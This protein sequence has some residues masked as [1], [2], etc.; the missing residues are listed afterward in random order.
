MAV[1]SYLWAVQTDDGREVC[2]ATADVAKVSEVKAR[3][4][5]GQV[6]IHRGDQVLA[7]APNP[8]GTIDLHR[9]PAEDKLSKSV[10]S[11]VVTV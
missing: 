2:S 7:S 3:V 9:W 4:V 10:S 11:R 5:G 6:E 8:G 1:R